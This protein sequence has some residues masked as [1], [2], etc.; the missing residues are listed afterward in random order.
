MAYLASEGTVVSGA[1]VDGCEEIL[2]PAALEF[3]A[4]LHRKFEGR[5]RELMDRRTQ[6]QDVSGRRPSRLLE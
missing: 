4:G 6:V 3:V 1:P 5:R 2:T